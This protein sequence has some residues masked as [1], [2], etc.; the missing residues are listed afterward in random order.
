MANKKNGRLGKGPKGS[1]PK[2][3]K[4]TKGIAG[5]RSAGNA[6][7]RPAGSATAKP[8]APMAN[9]PVRTA[10]SMSPVASAP[11]RDSLR[12]A[13]ALPTSSLRWTC[14]PLSP[15]GHP[16]TAAF[17]LGQDRPMQALRTGL[18]IHARGYN[19]FVSGLLGSGW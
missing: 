4:G 6:A 16:P 15:S 3:Q 1:A 12:A 18:S 7:K 9:K 10:A 14:P 17:L 2:S 13:T 8:T 5:A 19:L 11:K